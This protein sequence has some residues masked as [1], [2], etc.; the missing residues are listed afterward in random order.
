MAFTVSS[1]HDH[2][3]INLANPSPRRARGGGR[4]RDCGA[5]ADGYRCAK[6]REIAAAWQRKRRGD[7]C[8][9]ASRKPDVKELTVYDP[10]TGVFTWR[11]GRPRAP[12]GGSVGWLYDGYICM[13]VEGRKYRA[14]RLAFLY[15]TG[16]FPGSGSR[17][18]K[19][20]A[21]RQSMVQ[22]AR[23]HALAEPRELRSAV[24][25]QE[26]LQRCDPQSGVGWQRAG[27]GSLVDSAPL[28]M[29][30][31]LTTGL[32]SKGT[33]SSPGSISRQRDWR[34]WQE[35]GRGAPARPTISEA[36]VD[37]L[38]NVVTDAQARLDR[39]GRGND[40]SRQAQQFLAHMLDHGGAQLTER[41]E[42][43]SARIG[44]AFAQRLG[45]RVAARPRL[46]AVTVFLKAHALGEPHRRRA[47]AR[48]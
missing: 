30:P 41:A 46:L 26:R 33:A 47:R 2:S 14:H 20:Q 45:R 21:R 37:I 48:S 44:L 15:M 8:E 6:C 5:E 13:E 35:P 43:A 24:K 38:V 42:D 3:T 4:C 10:A 39:C 36:P 17:S 40:N 34:R 23:R 32:P 31:A 12:K 28:R 16:S 11:I 7:R 27:E 9:T 19:Q 1:L 18:Q 25:Q 29:Q 22:L